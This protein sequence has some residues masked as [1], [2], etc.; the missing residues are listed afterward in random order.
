MENHNEIA[1]FILPH[2]YK[3][4]KVFRESGF[5]AA[6]HNAAELAHAAGLGL[7]FALL[8]PV[9]PTPSHPESS[10]LG[11][12]EFARLCEHSPIPLFALGGMRPDMEETARTHGAHGIALLRNWS[13]R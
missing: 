9:L 4:I 1:R 11:W 7:D 3:I 8:S 6:C 5:S 2:L 12:A 13:A 10:G